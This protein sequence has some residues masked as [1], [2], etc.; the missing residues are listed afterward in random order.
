MQEREKRAASG[1]ADR[2][3][4]GKEGKV[5]ECGRGCTRGNGRQM[6]VEAGVGG[7]SPSCD[8]LINETNRV[9]CQKQKVLITRR[10]FV[11]S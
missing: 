11:W 8:G 3:G 9:Q 4:R 10:G 5:D 7:H 1:E 2:G 6:S